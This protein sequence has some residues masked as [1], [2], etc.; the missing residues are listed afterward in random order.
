MSCGAERASAA[1]LF[2]GRSSFLCFPYSF[3]A[4]RIGSLGFIILRDQALIIVSN[5]ALLIDSRFWMGRC[6]TAEYAC[7]GFAC[8]SSDAR[9]G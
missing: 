4:S 9:I 1:V 3:E 8:L 7:L 2:C 5:S 6:G